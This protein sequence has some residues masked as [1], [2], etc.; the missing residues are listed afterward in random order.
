VWLS[1]TSN[2]MSGDRGQH[3]GAEVPQYASQLYLQLYAEQHPHGPAINGA[4]AGLVRTDITRTQS[5]ILRVLFDSFTA[6]AGISPQRAAA[7]FVALACDP[8]LKGVS[9]HFFSQ[10]GRLEKRKKLAFSADEL[11]SLR[12]V[13]GRCS[14]LREAR[15]A[16]AL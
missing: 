9:G 2:R 8:A 3:D 16:C 1:D 7:N 13:L 5:G 14:E 4:L 6:I 10:P 11:D 15:L 12:R